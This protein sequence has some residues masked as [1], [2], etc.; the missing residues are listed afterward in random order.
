MRTLFR[1]W[2]AAATAALPL[3]LS[4]QTPSPARRITFSTTEGTWLSLDL[5]PDSARVV[6]E[7]LGDL[8]SVPLTGGAWRTSV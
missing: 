6:I 7:L 5:S 1:A 4:A 3:L 2:P 8:Y